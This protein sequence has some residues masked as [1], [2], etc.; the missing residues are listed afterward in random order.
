MSSA[1][2]CIKLLK[3]GSDVKAPYVFIL[4]VV[5]GTTGCWDEMLNSFTDALTPAFARALPAPR[6]EVEPGSAPRIMTEDD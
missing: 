3:Q 1:S 5:S 4:P 2:K 6:P